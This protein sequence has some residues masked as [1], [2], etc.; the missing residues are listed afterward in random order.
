MT[1][2]RAVI[3]APRADERGAILDVLRAAFGRE[4]EAQIVERLWR[5]GAIRR[6]LVG[7]INGAVAGY[8]ALSEV[9]AEPAIE[10]PLLGLAPVAVRPELHGR[11]IGT[12]LVRIALALARADGAKIVVVLGE[13]RY[14]ARFGFEP[15]SIYSFRWAAAD[16]GDAFQLVDYGGA[17]DGR[18]RAI[19]YHPAFSE[20]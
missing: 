7:E 20:G 10:G 19:H 16:A 12:R 9:V 14:Y 15:G 3:R 4:D 5:E 1:I 11:E 13:P 18:A 8:C 2:D 17:A 6:E